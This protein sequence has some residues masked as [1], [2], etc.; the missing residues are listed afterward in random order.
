MLQSQHPNKNAFSSRLNC[1][2]LMCNMSI[3]QGQKWCWT[4]TSNHG[5]QNSLDV[6]MLSTE[7]RLGNKERAYATHTH[8]HF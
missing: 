1:A 2:N 4:N 7:W 6:F 5:I 8:T 3:Q